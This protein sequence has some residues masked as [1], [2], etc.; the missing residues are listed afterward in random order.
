VRGVLA[1]QDVIISLSLPFYF[2][3]ECI[4]AAL[5]RHNVRFVENQTLRESMAAGVGKF[6]F[7]IYP[8]RECAEVGERAARPSDAADNS[9][10]GAAR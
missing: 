5:C 2:R 1:E 7:L 8:R 6:A 10:N 9:N 4:S 3:Q